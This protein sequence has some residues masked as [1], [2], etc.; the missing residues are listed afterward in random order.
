MSDESKTIDWPGAYAHTLEVLG[1][2]GKLVG[3]PNVN[4][5][6]GIAYL[7]SLLKRYESGERTEELYDDM[8]GSA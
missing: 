2:Y 4:P 5:Y 6:F 1:E 8:M 7:R 3:M